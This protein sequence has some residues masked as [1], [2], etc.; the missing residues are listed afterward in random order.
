MHSRCEEGSCRK[1]ATHGYPGSR[2]VRCGTHKLAH[3]VRAFFYS[4][5]LPD[6]DLLS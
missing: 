2:R 5:L 4:F 6:R 1:F 3:M